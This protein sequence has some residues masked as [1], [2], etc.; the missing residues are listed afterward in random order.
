MMDFLA[1]RRMRG[2]RRLAV[3]LVVAFS[4]LATSMAASASAEPPMVTKVN[5]AKGPVGGGTSVS[6]SGTNVTGALSVK[7]GAT[8]ATGFTVNSGGSITAIS[9][10]EPAGTVDVTVTTPGGTSPISSADRFKFFPT[11]TGLSPTSG[12]QAGGTSVTVTGT[13]FG[14]GTTAT[15]F[16]FG[17]AKAT[18]VNCGS[19]TTC[20]V[21]APVHK[22]GIVDVNATVNKVSTPKARPADQ[23]AYLPPVL[24]WDLTQAFAEH[25]KM[26]PLPDAFNNPNVW[27]WMHGETNAPSTYALLGVFFGPLAFEKECNFKNFY[28]WREARGATTP[29]ISY[30]AG[31]TQEK[32]Q[33]C[34]PS[35]EFPTKTVFTSPQL[36]GSQDSVVRWTSPITGVV[37]VSGSIQCVDEKVEGIVWQLDQGSSILLGPSTK[38]DNTLTA[39]GPISVPVTAGES[40]YLD[41]GRGA[42]EGGFDTTAITLHIT[43]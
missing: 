28:T 25:P 18:S 27:G 4:A 35:A 41:I 12:P 33:T 29:G 37:T 40:L 13:G 24:T 14:L 10:T 9:P 17:L 32:G 21:V 15:I 8:E 38:A 16:K 34:V 39:F 19:T 31:P 1:Q 22:A 30:N 2:S 6:I 20:T 36:N 5:P 3:G 43:S 42:V 23:F 7:F 11:I 26:N